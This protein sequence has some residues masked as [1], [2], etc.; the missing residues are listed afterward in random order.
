MDNL[1]ENNIETTEDYQDH[2]SVKRQL[3]KWKIGIPE[4]NAT[5]DMCCPDFSCCV[6]DCLASKEERIAFANGDNNTRLNMCMNFLRVLMEKTKVIDTN[7]VYISGELED[8]KLNI[9][10]Q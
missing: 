9:N 2:P 3:A 4:H 10:N 6:P 5:L 7:Q 8:P 1:I